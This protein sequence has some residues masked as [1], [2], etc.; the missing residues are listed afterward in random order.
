MFCDHWFKHLR[1]TAHALAALRE[2]DGSEPRPKLIVIDP[3]RT[4]VAEKADIWLQIRPGTDAALFL[5]WINVIIEENLYDKNFVDKWTFGFDQLKQ[6][7]SEYTPE[8][9]AEITWIPAEKIRE[10][11]RIVRHEQAVP[12][13][14][15][16]GYRP[17]R[18]EWTACGTG[19]DLPAYYKWK[20]GRAGYRE[21]DRAGPDRQR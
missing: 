1:I 2:R 7:A 3:R 15:G 5:A 9:V 16:I 14:H 20:Y 10:S 19:P 4:K 17:N 6:R 18:S 21:P 13:Q 12:Y 8:R 11:A